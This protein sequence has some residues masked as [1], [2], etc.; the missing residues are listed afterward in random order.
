M[1]FRQG[2]FEQATS[3]SKGATS[4]SKG[5]VGGQAPTEAKVLEAKSLVAKE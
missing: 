3:G 2:H 4:G 5:R 1:T